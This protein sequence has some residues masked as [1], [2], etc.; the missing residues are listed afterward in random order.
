MQEGTLILLE[1]SMGSVT[2]AL[3]ADPFLS[4]SSQLIL[5]RSILLA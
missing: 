4:T 3:Q 1:Q 2:S 5:V